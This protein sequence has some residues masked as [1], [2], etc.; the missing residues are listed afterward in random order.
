MGSLQGV[1]DGFLHSH[2]FWKKKCEFVASLHYFFYKTKIINWHQLEGNWDCNKEQLVDIC[3][4]PA[5]EAIF[6]VE[7]DPHIGNKENQPCHPHQ[8]LY[9]KPGSSAKSGFKCPDPKSNGDA[10]FPFNDWIIPPV[11]SLIRTV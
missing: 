1:I 5:S 11:L 10:S 4:L 9:T 6:L 3:K 7:T 8:K 2:H